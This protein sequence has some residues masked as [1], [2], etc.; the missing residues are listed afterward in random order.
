MIPVTRQ[1][2]IKGKAREV[3]SSFWRNREKIWPVAPDA[4]S[5]F[6]VKVDVLASDHIGLSLERPEAIESEAVGFEVA[7]T[8]DR[9]NRRITIAQRFPSE[10]RRFTTAHEIGHWFLHPGLSYH[11]DRP[12]QGGEHSNPA[13]KPIEQEADLFAAELLMPR[14][15][16]L[17]RFSDT[18]GTPISGK[19]KNKIEALWLHGQHLS[20]SRLQAELRLRSLLVAEAGSFDYRIFVPLYKDFGVS[21][22]AMAIQLEDLELVT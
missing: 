21:L 11:R 1:G 15:R 8:M 22:T 3:L 10:Y 9:P 18:F 12:M 5:F 20:L 17:D 2:E 16:L 6:P 4:D 14:K 7:G 13:R 19:D